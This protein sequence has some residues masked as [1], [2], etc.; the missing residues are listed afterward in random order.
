MQGE[1]G[2]QRVDVSTLL[3]FAQVASHGGIRE[4][5]VIRYRE[6][7]HPEASALHDSLSPL[8]GEP[9]SRAGT[10]HWGSRPKRLFFRYHDQSPVFRSEGLKRTTSPRMDKGRPNRQS[11]VSD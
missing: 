9:S 6:R 3:R 5:Q 8:V 2:R 1:E 11:Q 10:D 4:S 7:N